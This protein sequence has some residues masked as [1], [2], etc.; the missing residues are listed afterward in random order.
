M[1]KTIIVS[2]LVLFALAYACTKD[3]EAADQFQDQLVGKW[4]LTSAYWNSHYNGFN[5][6][7]SAKFS[8]N[9]LSYEFTK[10][11]KVISIS[12]TIKIR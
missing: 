7:D 11:G 9:E 8:V 12:P 1:K 3:T 10:D 2:T 5:N 4:H 6:K